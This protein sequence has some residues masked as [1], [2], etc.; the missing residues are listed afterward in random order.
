MSPISCRPISSR[1]SRS[2]SSLT[3]PGKASTRRRRTE[4]MSRRFFDPQPFSVGVQ[5]DLG[6][7]ASHHIG[8]VLR[9]RVDDEIDLFNGEGGEYRA[10]IVA[11]SKKAV[12]VLP[13]SFEQDDRIAPRAVTLALPL[14]K[15][16]RMD[17]AIQKA[18]EMGVHAIQLLQC[19]RSDV[20]LNQEREEKK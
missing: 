15:G 9:M 4:H 5:A 3:W 11:I 10:R 20:R 1:R 16:E 8:R 6:E 18:T 14:I 7:L 19:E 17:Y 12:T 13:R 2:T